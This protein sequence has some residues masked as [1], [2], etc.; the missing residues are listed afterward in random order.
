[1]SKA[2]FLTK[3]TKISFLLYNC[4]LSRVFSLL[5][6]SFFSVLQLVISLFLISQYLH[7]MI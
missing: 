3:M 6:K 2:L 1:M 7:C 5:V 4:D